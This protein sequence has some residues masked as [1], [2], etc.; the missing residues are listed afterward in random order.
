MG[1]PTL[2]RVAV[3]VGVGSYVAVLQSVLAALLSMVLSAMFDPVVGWAGVRWFLLL[4][5]VAVL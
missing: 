1:G 5:A 4:L 3:S 2:S